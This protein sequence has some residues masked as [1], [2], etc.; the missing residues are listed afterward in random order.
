MIKGGLDIV[1]TSDQIAFSPYNPPVRYLRSESSLHPLSRDPVSHPLL[2]S[3]VKR[4]T[5]NIHQYTFTVPLSPSSS[6]SPSTAF[7]PGQHIL[8]DFS[9]AIPKRYSH[10]NEAKPQRLNDDFVR[11]W[12][13]SSSPSYLSPST[14]PTPSLSVS[15]TIKLK[16]SGEITPFLHY[17]ASLPASER[18]PLP[19]FHRGINGSFSVFNIPLSLEDPSSPPPL[20]LENDKLLFIAGGIGATPFLSF[21]SSLRLLPGLRPDISVLFSCRSDEIVLVNNFF[22]VSDKGELTLSPFVSEIQVFQT[23]ISS[24]SFFF[25]FSLLF[26]SHSI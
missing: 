9:K 19:L 25:S 22:D 20:T 16:E 17:Y 15:C 4:I 8:V 7:I 18:P 24:L 13:I 10:M 3:D 1:Q 23:G 12:T 2:I 5:P 26:F 6:P 14:S 21:H 11:S